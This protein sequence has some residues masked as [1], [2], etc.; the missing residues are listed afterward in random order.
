MK[1]AAAL[2][3]FAAAAFAQLPDDARKRVDQVV[4]K[5]LADTAIPGAS[6]AIVTGGKISYEHAYGLARLDPKLAAEASMRYK[7]GSNSKQITSAAVL[8]LAAEGKLSLD[9]RVSKY[10]P[11]LT[12][13]RDVTIRELLSHQSGYQDYYAID[14]TPPFMTQPTSAEHILDAWARK[15][16][17]F[18]PGSQYQ[19]SNTNYVIAGLIFEKVAGQSLM[20]YLRAHVFEPLGMKSPVDL[21]HDQWAA[22]DPTGYT[23][24]ALGPMRPAIA[25][26]P[27]WLMAAGELAMT[28]GDLARWD[29]SL[30]NGTILKP[31]QLRE[32]TTEVP[33]TTGSGARYGLG[34]SVGSANGRRVWSHTGGVSGFNS[35]NYVYP[36]DHISITVLTNGEGPAHSQIV[37][38]LQPILLPSA[39]DPDE[40]RDHDRALAIFIGLQQ[41]KLD[42]S[43]LT[44]DANAYFTAQAIGDFAASLKPLGKPASFTQ[45]SVSHRGGMTYRIYAAK[46]GGKTLSVQL[47]LMPDGKIDQYLVRPQAQ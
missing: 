7:I 16:L 36:D 19:Y 18:E 24:Y 30:M 46:A 12:R 31:A 6:V 26:G 13:A 33:F 5:A 39:A 37:R 11:D 10:L 14:F 29:I 23:R 9:D 2:L 38:K 41:G 45:S 8:L 25:E 34:I 1:S 42:R 32:L 17:D 3:A 4:E 40:S 43:L 44:E 22:S 35:S 27:G 47:Y 20:M 15:P 28:A 21:D